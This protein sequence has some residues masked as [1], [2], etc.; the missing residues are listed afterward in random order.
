[1]KKKVILVTLFF[2]TVSCLFAQRIQTM[3]FRN[4]PIAE[5]IM[6]LADSAGA[7]V[8][9][10]ETVTGL[11]TFH[12]TDSSF[13]DALLRF[14]EASRLHAV[15]RD[16]VWYLSRIAI[17]SNERGVSVSAEDVELEHLIRAL[18][19]T[20]RVTI[21]HDQ[22]PRMQLSVFVQ[23]RSV[24][25]ILEILIQRLPEYSVVQESGAWYLRRRPDQFASTAAAGRLSSSSIVR[26]GD[27]YTMNIVRGNF[28]AI[29]ALLFSVGEKEF[30]LLN[31]TD[32]I[33]ENLFFADKEFEELLRLICEQGNSDFAIANNIYY[34]FE[35]QRRDVLKKLKP[36]LSEI[37]CKCLFI[38]RTEPALFQTQWQTGLALA[39]IAVLA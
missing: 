6:I 25:N 11:A 35:I 3:D 28:F 7:S 14:S 34:I 1:M 5:I 30:S 16:G 15:E 31:R 27:R 33:L 32:S 12:F 8:I 18:A 36:E 19:R 23:D 21:L 4:R 9:I 38:I 10:D 2:I 24:Q 13:E 20:A 29:V 17:S 26:H 37:L 22:L 39:P